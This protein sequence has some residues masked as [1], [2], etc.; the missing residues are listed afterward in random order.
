[1]LGLDRAG[2]LT[3]ALFPFWAQAHETSGPTIFVSALLQVE[4]S[5]NGP[6]TS[7]LMDFTTWM[8]SKRIVSLAQ[9]TNGDTLI[10]DLLETAMTQLRRIP[11]DRAAIAGIDTVIAFWTYWS[12]RPKVEIPGLE[13]VTASHQFPQLGLLVENFVRL[14]PQTKDRLA[15]AVG[16]M[17]MDRPLAL[18]SW[19]ARG[20][21]PLLVRLFVRS[22]GS[23]HYIPASGALWPCLITEF[24]R[25]PRCFVRAP[26]A[27]VSA[28]V[29]TLQHD[30]NSRSRFLD[31]LLSTGRYN[32]VWS[33]LG[34]TAS[35][36][37][38]DTVNLGGLLVLLNAAKVRGVLLD[39]LDETIKGNLA[40]YV[41]RD[42]GLFLAGDSW[43]YISRSLWGGGV[44]V[45][46]H[47]S[48]TI[49]HRI[50][51]SA[52]GYVRNMNQDMLENFVISLMCFDEE[53]QR[54]EQ[55]SVRGELVSV[56]ELLGFEY[57]SRLLK[58]M[59]GCL[60]AQKG[61]LIWADQDKARVIGAAF[62]RMSRL[63]ETFEA[64]FFNSIDEQDQKVVDFFRSAGIVI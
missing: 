53:E 39:Q 26:M 58:M 45:L 54:T 22:D 47:F 18:E 60:R 28:Y 30:L 10:A 61:K 52:K 12:L 57:Y 16:L 40:S 59:R 11:L 20:L 55:V 25:Q 5:R 38:A 50:E 51:R 63:I 24:C 27:L 35:Q 17:A 29:T 36:S 56:I 44:R 8:G 15:E 4:P 3:D 9:A 43:S 14:P 7:A 42:L 31:E 49:K 37:D 2:A 6:F 34:G 48:D 1:M 32:A 19:I 64:D 41:L 23:L 13:V 62:N 46:R 21:G 33:A